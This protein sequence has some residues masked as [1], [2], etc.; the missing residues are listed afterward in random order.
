MNL[1]SKKILP[2]GTRFIDPNL[3]F[4]A[5]GMLSQFIETIHEKMDYRIE[6]E[7]L[8]VIKPDR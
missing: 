6:A 3:R 5:E 1:Y 2:P 4:S 8:I 7:N